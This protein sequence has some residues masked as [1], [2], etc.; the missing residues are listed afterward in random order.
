MI[1]FTAIR[2]VEIAALL[3]LMSFVIYAL[4]G[5]MPGDPIDLMRS[6][7]PRVSAAD[8]ARLKAVYGLDR[9][10]IERYF[11]WLGQALAGRTRLFAAVRRAGLGGAAA[12]AR[13][14]A[15]ADGVE[16]R[17]GAAAGA[18]A[19]D[20]RGA[21]AGFAARRRDQP[22]LLRR[23]LDADLLAGAGADP[24]FRRRARLAAGERHRDRRGSAMPATGCATSYCRWRR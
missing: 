14:L 22:V 20:R 15:V 4:I 12:A 2:L 1:R 7:D 11:A 13:Q 6:A 19:R 24:G 3:L 8:V 17:A 10:L 9:P 23:H 16:L 21:A 5:L 18:G